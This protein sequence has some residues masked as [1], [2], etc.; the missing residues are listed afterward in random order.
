MERLAGSIMLMSGW[1]R[2]VVAMAAGAFAVIALPPFGFFAAM[3]VSFTLLVFLLD[4]AS[5]KPGSPFV[6]RLAPAFVIGW[7]FGFGYLVAGLWWMGNA[8]LVEAEDY[9]WALPLAMVGLP[10]GL[11]LFYGLAGALARMF[12]LD[13]FGRIAAL[14]FAFGL[15]EWL[16]SVL[17]TGFPWNAVGQGIMPFPLMMQSIRIVSADGMNVIAV[18]IFASPALI[19]TKKSMGAGL[20]LA[21][22][23]LAAHLGFGAWSI[24]RPMAT[25][26]V[27]APV[28]RLV[29]PVID[30]AA[31]I[32]NEDRK[33]IFETHLALSR[34]RPKTGNRKPDYIIWPETAIPFILTENPAALARIAEV[35]DDNQ[36]LIAGAVRSEDP[37][38]GLAPRYYNSIYMIDGT[39]QIIGAYDKVHLVPF[40]EYLPFEDVLDSFGLKAVAA[41]PGGFSAAARHGLLNAPDGRRFYPL[42]C[43]EII[44]GQ[45]ITSDAR[46]ADAIVNLTNDGWFGNTP[47][48]WQHFHQ[49][50]LRAVETGLPVIRNS[51]SGISSIISATGETPAGLGFGIF[52]YVDLPLPPKA[53]PILD[54]QERTFNF[55]LL[56]ALSF[57]IAAYSRVGFI[58]FRN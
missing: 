46:D 21:G 10:A 12:W 57:L 55:W 15:A 13:G 22:M 58:F 49:A 2:A 17:F 47:G 54:S 9:A 52:G 26:A 24:S 41:M 40:G 29:Q 35:L 7:L 4:G 23:L 27:Q 18:L 1:K 44:F 28:I 45:D 25:D 51:N 6:A 48:P 33:T 50:R 39:G 31:K 53:S 30:Q 20:A 34:E 11:A 5:G 43:Y 14:A 19:A 36:I 8:L 42:V 37:G 3:F 16:R 56:E 38:G 32:G